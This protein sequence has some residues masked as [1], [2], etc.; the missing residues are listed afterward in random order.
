MEGVLVN[1]ATE[2]TWLKIEKLLG[3]SINGL[4]YHLQM[5]VLLSL[6]KNLFL[7]PPLPPFI[8]DLLPIFGQR[9]HPDS[10]PNP[11]TRRPALEPS[12]R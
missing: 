12:P 6:I 8:T 3:Q 7:I 10:L 5:F 9:C 11:L 2:L 1:N 4:Q